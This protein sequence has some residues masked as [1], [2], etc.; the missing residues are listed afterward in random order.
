MSADN[1]NTE[2]S[3]PGNTLVRRVFSVLALVVSAVCGA[4]VPRNPNR[5]VFGSWVGVGEGTLELARELRTLEPETEIIWIVADE[6]QAQQAEAEGFSSELRNS[7]A[8]YWATLTARYVVITHGDNDVNRFGVV[9]AFVIHLGHGVPLKR[10]HHHISAAIEGPGVVKAIMR[11]IN[12]K[13]S[14][15]VSLYVASSVTSAERLRVA[16]R[17]APGRVRVLG[18]PRDDVVCRQASDPALAAKARTALHGLLGVQPEKTNPGEQQEKLLLYA[19]TWRDGS[20]DPGVPSTEE[21]NRLQHF[22]TQQG[23]RLVIRS[24]PMGHGAYEHMLDCD[25][26][27]MLTAETVADIT[28]L[29]GGFDAIVSDYSSIVI[30]YALLGRPIVWFAP[31]LAEYVATR[32]L[33]EALEVTSAGQVQATW[34][35]VVE[36]LERVFA[37]GLTAREAAADALALAARFHAYPEGN[38]AERVLAEVRR[39]ELPDEQRIAEG[40]FFESFEGRQVSCNPLAIDREIASR[41]PELP[42]YWSVTSENVRVPD[43]AIALLKGGPDWVV[44]RKRAKLLVVNDWLGSGF[45]RGR[46]QT[47]LQTWHGTMLKH[48]ALTRPHTGFQTRIATKRESKR[49]SLLLSQNPHSTAQ[50]K[51]SYAYKGEILETGYPRD[52]RLARSL[53]NSD[54]GPERIDFVVQAAQRTLGVPEGARVLVYAPTWRESSRGKVSG[55]VDL[56]DVHALANELDRPDDPWVVLTRGHSRTHHIGSYGYLGAT[57]RVIDVSRHPDVNDVL[58]A[59]DLLVTDYSSLMF[60]AA[61]AAVPMAF[62]VPDLEQYR[63]QERGFTFDFEEAAPGPLL[64]EREELVEVARTGVP[65][66]SAYR[67]W[68]QRFV[69]HED[70]R[71]AERVVDE[72][73]ARGAL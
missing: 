46:G 72:L 10:L 35:Q 45:R 71:A 70:G 62:Y 20:A 53:V 15:R 24:H 5:W 47:V 14:E 31:D 68:Q 43:G 32:G 9:G 66:G 39:L 17:V 27:H 29:L 41:L 69:L 23:A 12:R 22:L 36:R 30:D 26:I 16:N 28:P 49:W 63:D 6:H 18:D 59:A 34:D 51:R 44:A 3:G 8:G 73:V 48:L 11:W 25:R 13:R 33:Y 50:F 1:F 42:R 54:S 61:V 7:W 65:Y 37:P 55:V 57:A 38:A 64:T 58:L 56:L 2:T 60:D 67:E 21:L 52:D 19:P 40:V 4:L